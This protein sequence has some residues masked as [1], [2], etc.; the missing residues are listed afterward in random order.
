MRQTFRNLTANA[1]LVTVFLFLM[2]VVL[3]SRPTAW[4]GTPLPIIHDEFGYILLGETFAH[5]RLTNPP[6]PGPLEFFQTYYQFQTPRYYAMYPPGQGLALALGVLLGQPIIGIWIV[7]G[8]WAIALYWMMRGLMS[9]G[10]ALAGALAGM[11]GYGAF[12]YW[13]QSFWGGSVLALGGTLTFGGMIRLWRQRGSAVSAAAWAGV[14]CII[15]AL[16]RPLDGCIFALWPTALILWNGRERLRRGDKTNGLSVLASFALLALVGV[17]L[18]LGYNVATTGDAFLFAHR[19]YST[20]Y[21][22]AFSMFVWQHPHGDT[23]EVPPFMLGLEKLMPSYLT[24]YPLTWA[25]RWDSLKTAWRT[26]QPF[27]LPM[28]LW[29]LATL[30]LIAGWRA[31]DRWVRRS[32]ISLAFIALPLAI[33]RFYDKPHYLA[34]W[35]APLLIIVMQGARHLHVFARRQKWRPTWLGLAIALVLLTAFPV[36]RVY[37]D[38]HLSVPY[39]T[40]QPW[41]IDRHN[42]EVKLM[43]YAAAT[44]R[45]QL[46]A[47]VYPPVHNF[48]H[49]WVFNSA[50]PAAQPVLWARSLGE[51][52]DRKLFDAFPQYDHWAVLTDADGGLYKAVLIPKT[53]S[54]GPASP[55]TPAAEKP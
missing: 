1:W 49:D 54:A 20:I 24:E 25:T 4:Y 31:R 38:F 27:M 47:V 15:M 8:A 36:L 52:R 50:D 44:G 21:Q 48:H 6:P 13:G 32:L 34:A 33:V 5:G 40:T 11:A 43:E 37:Y 53:A 30:G 55:A 28:S 16:T 41:A 12:S 19:L 23:A 42:L 22:P 9:R 10:W 51:D 29:P 18:T 14:G 26:E 7:N 17:A 46:V 3:T 39:W 45:R 2:G 35:T